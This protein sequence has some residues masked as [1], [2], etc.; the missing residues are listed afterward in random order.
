MEGVGVR[1]AGKLLPNGWK[2]RKP[3]INEVANE[4]VGMVGTI[5]NITRAT[6]PWWNGQVI[7]HNTG[8]RWAEDAMLRALEPQ[9]AIERRFRMNAPLDYRV[10]PNVED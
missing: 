10:N 6:N 2:K 3:I 7:V 1:S 5:G 9:G 8:L 4:A